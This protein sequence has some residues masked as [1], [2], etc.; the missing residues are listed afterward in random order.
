LLVALMTA[1]V[2]YALRPLVALKR[3][4]LA[5]AHW[6]ATHTPA[7]S[8]VAAVD[9]G[10]A[11]RRYS[12]RDVLM[13]HKTH[14]ATWPLPAGD[15]PGL[16]LV[17]DEAFIERHRLKSPQ[18]GDRTADLGPHAVWLRRH[19]RLTPLARVCRWEIL[20]VNAPAFST[21]ER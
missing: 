19:A 18:P 7:G 11:L 12:G 13:L 4:E 14:P 3:C 17:W 21:R 20:R 5:V 9:V 10:L 8:R 15:A 16:Y 2:H 6:V 1:G